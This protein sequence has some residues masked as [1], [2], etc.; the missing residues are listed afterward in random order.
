MGIVERY[1][2]SVMAKEGTSEWWVTAS[3][4]TEIWDGMW[5]SMSDEQHRQAHELYRERHAVKESAQQP[6]T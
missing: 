4:Q 1:V 3:I 5:E 2:S 6:P